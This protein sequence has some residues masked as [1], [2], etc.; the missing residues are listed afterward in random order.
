[1]T[2]CV[3]VEVSAALLVVEAS[4]I[5]SLLES[6]TT[7]KYGTISST[8]ETIGANIS[9]RNTSSIGGELNSTISGVGFSESVWSAVK[10]S[11]A[12]EVVN[13][14]ACVNWLSDT[15]RIVTADA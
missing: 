8:D 4:L 7:V 11:I 12:V 13:V 1:M 5:L 9:T 10:T 2:L 3:T 14:A 15:D 6:S